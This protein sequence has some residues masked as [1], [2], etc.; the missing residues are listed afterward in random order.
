LNYPSYLNCLG[1][2]GLIYKPG[3]FIFIRAPLLENLLEN[4]KSISKLNI[5]KL[6]EILCCY[7]SCYP[8][9]NCLDIKKYICLP[10]EICK[11]KI[12]IITPDC[13]RG[14]CIF[15]VSHLTTTIYE[16]VDK[17]L[18]G[19]IGELIYSDIGNY[20]NIDAYN[21]LHDL[22]AT[23][24]KKAKKDNEVTIL[25]FI[26]DF[27]YYSYSNEQKNII[28]DMDSNYEDAG[29][30]IIHTSIDLGENKRY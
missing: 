14:G 17:Y 2:Y 9:F 18:R 3:D 12:P 28:K 16:F 10:Q 29:I 25:K 30:G 15:G 20:N 5:C 4:R 27:F 19:C 26:D 13:Y 7:S 6:S 11:Y 22:L 24:Y 23:I 8:S 1:T 21:F